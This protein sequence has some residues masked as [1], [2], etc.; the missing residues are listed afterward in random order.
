VHPGVEGVQLTDRSFDQ[1]RSGEAFG[2][3]EGVVIERGEQLTQAV[4]IPRVARHT[5]QFALQLVGTDGESPDRL[6]RERLRQVVLDPGL[7]VTPGNRGGRQAAGLDAV[8]RTHLRERSLRR[9]TFFEGEGRSGRGR[10]SDEDHR[11]KH[12][13]QDCRDPDSAGLATHTDLLD[14]VP[15]PIRGAGLPFVACVSSRRCSRDPG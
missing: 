12:S 13:R 1:R 11:Q 14:S 2:G 8:T 10:A 9:D 4:G 5:V 7:Q 15:E 6:Q 3:E